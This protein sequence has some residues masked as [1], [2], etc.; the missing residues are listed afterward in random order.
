MSG[1][2]EHALGLV[3]IGRTSG[4]L[5]AEQEGARL[6]DVQSFRKYVGGSATN[7]A[8]GTARLGVKSAMLTRVGDEHMGRF[9]RR[10]LAE[11]G[12][13][14]GQVRFDPEHLTPYVLLAVRAIEDFPRIF[15][16]GDAADLAVGEGDVEPDFIASSKAL[17]I[18]GTP[19]SRSGSRAACCKAIQA[20]NEAGTSI[21]FDLDYRPVFWGVATHEQ[22]GEMFVASEKVTEVYRSVLPDCDLVV[23]TE[24]EI[25]IAGGSTE[26]PDRKSVV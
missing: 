12:V 25:R 20:A 3:C 23:G 8:V 5:Y 2:R 22:G 26:T 15:A 13:D 14:V 21:V 6:E 16:Y 19:L 24:E 17:L 4:D 7:I 18:T 11:N 10:T 9:V 1:G